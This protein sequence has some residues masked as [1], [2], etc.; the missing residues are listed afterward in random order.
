MSKS[1][2]NNPDEL[3]DP[4]LQ[5]LAWDR[6]LCSHRQADWNKASL[7]LDYRAIYEHLEPQAALLPGSRR[8]IAALQDVSLEKRAY[9][10]L[11][12]FLG[13]HDLDDKVLAKAKNLLARAGNPVFCNAMPEC[14]ATVH[15]W[16]IGVL[17]PLL[18]YLWSHYTYNKQEL[19]SVPCQS[20]S[21]TPSE[22]LEKL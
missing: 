19:P 12:S 2:Q 1:M 14:S 16:C 7:D 10:A 11:T 18:A 22:P 20:L 4:T 17:E 3:F 8:P 15:H 21:S 5:L 13:E 9:D 6:H